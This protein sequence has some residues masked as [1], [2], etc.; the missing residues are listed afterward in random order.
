[1]KNDYIFINETLAMPIEPGLVQ[2]TCLY[3]THYISI[4]AP[5]LSQG[6]KM[7]HNPEKLHT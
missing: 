7:A 1:M 2:E 6:W 5:L 4:L 3:A